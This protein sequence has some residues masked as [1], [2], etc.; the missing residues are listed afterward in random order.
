MAQEGSDGLY[1]GEESGLDAEELMHLAIKAMN[2]DR[3]DDAILFLKHAIS[4]SPEEG[5]LHYLL[6]AVHAQ[7]GM[8]ERAIQEIERALS[9]DPTLGTAAFQLGLLYMAKGEV[10][11]A[12]QAWAP[13]DDL[14]EDNALRLFKNGMVRFLEE[15]Y[16]GAIEWLQRGIELNDV[17]ESLNDNMAQVIEQAQALVDAPGA[18]EKGVS[19]Q[20][21]AVQGTTS[22]AGRSGQVLGGELAA[23]Q[24]VLLAGYRKQDKEH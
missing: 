11:L 23:K 13:L 15:D 21:A 10:S 2:Q 8:R 3:D 19:R 18:S 1:E 14:A 4:L 22:A 6:G 7:L 17:A 5:R 9:Y 12:R 20:G 16:A 24:H